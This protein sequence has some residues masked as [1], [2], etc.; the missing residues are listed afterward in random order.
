MLELITVDGIARGVVA[1]H[2]LSGELE[3]H[4]AAPCCSAAVVQQRLLPLDECT[5]IQPV[6]SGAPTAKG[7]CSQ[8]LFHPD[9]SHHSQ[10]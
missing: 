5:E 7:P 2:L 8:P 4:T 9:S 10:R 1:R 6:R 3:V